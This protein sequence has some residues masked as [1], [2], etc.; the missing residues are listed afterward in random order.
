MTMPAIDWELLASSGSRHER[1][2]LDYFT[3][4]LPQRLFLEDRHNNVVWRDGNQLGKTTA[5]ILDTIYRCRGVH[6]FQ[7]VRRAPVNM[8]VISVSHEQMGT[9]GGFMEKLWEWL[10]KDEISGG[11]ERG[12][13]ITGKPPRIN[14]IDGPGKGSGISFGTYAQGASRFA[15]VTVDGVLLDEPPKQEVYGEIMPRLLVKDGSVRISMTPTPDMPDCAWLQELCAKKEF[16]EHNYT[17]KAEHCWPE[18]W[19]APYMPQDRIDR[20]ERTLAADEVEMRMGRSWT[21][22]VTGR[23]V[24]TFTR[25]NIR[26]D[27]PPR[28]STL[29]ISIDHGTQPGKQRAMLIAMQH[30]RTPEP[31]IWW[32][33]EVP[34]QDKSTTVDQDADFIVEMLARNRLSYWNIDRW[35]G[36]RNTGKADD[37]TEK[38]NAMLQ[39]SLA[40]RLGIPQSE[41]KPIEPA[42]KW[43]GSVRWGAILMSLVFD[44]F[45]EFGEPHGVVH[46]RCVGFITAVQRFAGD[47]RDKVKDDWDAGRYGPQTLV[48]V[49]QVNMFFRA[50]Y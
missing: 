5:V 11:F 1:R 16:I 7:P 12:R 39:A 40:K 49:D 32:Y 19:P 38:S 25:E 22:T 48:D 36:D 2:K 10:P 6:P 8:L 14:F 37:G 29:C 4:T 26:D 31:R 17:L 21:G 13:G 15:G 33:D 24:R 28:N 9:V 41:M 27:R 20:F 50:V 30:E 47:P 35:I 44:R 34:P 3:P 46:P 23:W 43:D 45:D 42:K 18:G